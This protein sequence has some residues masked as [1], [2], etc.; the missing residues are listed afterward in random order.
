MNVIDRGKELL[1][2]KSHPELAGLEER[3]NKETGNSGDI[4]V[5]K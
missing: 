3:F 5:V 4:K 1:D 2:V